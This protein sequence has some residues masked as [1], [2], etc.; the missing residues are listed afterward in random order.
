[1][2]QIVNEIQVK[3]PSVE[4]ADTILELEK[5]IKNT[6]ATIDRNKSELRKLKDMIESALLNNEPYRL[7]AEKAKQVAR[8]KGIAKLKVFQNKA[9]R[10]VADKVTD[11]C[12]ENRELKTA[13]GE[14]A[15]E[16]ARLSG[17]NEIEVDDGRTYRIVSSCQLV[18]NFK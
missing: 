8:E 18:L 16:Y 7:A 3:K 6:V 2:V 5:M 17:A 11:L 9:T 4:A 12:V 15:R 10:Q 13:L 1:M 14:Y